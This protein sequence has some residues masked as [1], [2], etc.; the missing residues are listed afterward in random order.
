MKP[1]KVIRRPHWQ[2]HIRDH[3]YQADVLSEAQQNYWIEALAQPF[4]I[5]FHTQE[6][7]AIATATE[8]H[9]HYAS[10]F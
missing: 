1:I 4:A 3:A 2:A 8:A 6:E 7:T 10:G 5:Q 9:G